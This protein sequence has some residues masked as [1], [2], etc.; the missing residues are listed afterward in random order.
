MIRISVIRCT[1]RFSPPQSLRS[2]LLA[3]RF[4]GGITSSTEASISS[5]SYIRND[6][7]I[8]N[9]DNFQNETPNSSYSIPLLTEKFHNRH[10]TGAYAKL[11]TASKTDAKVVLEDLKRKLH[12]EFNT[13]TS[14]SHE[15]KVKRTNSIKLINYINPQLKDISPLIYLI[16]AGRFPKGFLEFNG[17]SSKV[18]L[19]TFLL[20]NLAYKEFMLHKIVTSKEVDQNF[21]DLSNPAQ[22]FPEARKMKRKIIMHV[23]PTNSGKT[24]NSLKRLAEAKTGYYAGPL[25]LLAREIYEK[26]LSEKV[27]CNL[28]TGEEVIPCMDKFGKVSGISSGTIEMIPLHKKMDICVIDEIQ[29][30]AD[31]SRGSIWTNALLGVLA[32]EIHLCGE[33]SAV[34]LIK[35]IAKITGDEVEVKKYKRLGD[36]KVADKAVSYN[37]LEKGDCLVAFSKHKILQLKCEIERRTK[38][39]VGVVYGALPPEIRSEQSRKFNSGEFDILVASDAVGMGLNLK[40][41]RIIFQT[42]R[43]FDGKG[44]TNL[45]V[46]SLKQIAGRAGRFTKEGGMQTGYVS[47]LSAK[48]LGYI[49]SAMNAPIRDLEKAALW[50]TFEI[51][52][53]Y[54]AKFSKD[55]SLYD[56]LVQFEKESR[57]KRMENYYL[58]TADDK[59]ELMKLFLRDNL[60]K[61]V[62]IDDQLILSLC[63]INLNMTSPEVTQTTFKYIKNVYERCSKTV[64]DFGYIDTKLLTSSPNLASINF[65][66]ST[67]LLRHLEDHHKVVLMFM[68]LSQRFPTLF[69]DKESATE[70]KTLIEKRIQ[71]ELMHLKR[72]SR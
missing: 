27:R 55:D 13:F 23:G 35:K 31:P 14:L 12:D 68:W 25:R 3:K 48:D 30:I 61:K 72:I 63:P 4:L 62:P 59:A 2:A 1:H 19:I 38:F 54:M 65:D 15:E 24:Y 8:Y 57:D 6:S 36:L 43:K 34:P 5:P 52:K 51:W 60:Y 69:V 20:T 45:T 22:W 32:K 26:F 33:E 37:K 64:F 46:S 18:D 53:Q 17:L 58:A 39:S 50:P 9:T 66:K 11:N 70:L 49:K 40:I 21:I 67:A 28:I 71:Q 42:V 44:M 56:S 7:N 29:M 10:F 47:A 16:S 41:K